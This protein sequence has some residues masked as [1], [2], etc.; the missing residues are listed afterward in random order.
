MFWNYMYTPFFNRFVLLIVIILSSLID[1]VCYCFIKAPSGKENK[2]QLEHGISIKN[3]HKFSSEI[4]LS[5]VQ[6]KVV[7]PIL[8]CLSKW[9]HFLCQKKTAFSFMIAQL[10]RVL[11]AFLKKIKLNRMNIR[12]VGVLIYV[13]F[14]FKWNF[15][16]VSDKNVWSRIRAFFFV[17]KTKVLIELQVKYWWSL[18][19]K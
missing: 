16:T 8:L 1:E 18:K 2:T 11:K 6:V 17:P 15:K 19:L 3:Y 7:L 12:K 13:L 10:Q 5:L 9:A 4:V 14:L